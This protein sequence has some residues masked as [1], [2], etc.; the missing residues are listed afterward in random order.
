M[1]NEVMRRLIKTYPRHG[2]CCSEIRVFSSV[3]DT[4]ATKKLYYNKTR[5]HDEEICTSTGKSTFIKVSLNWMGIR[6]LWFPNL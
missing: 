6:K 2:G 5:D 3:R 4:K 1:H